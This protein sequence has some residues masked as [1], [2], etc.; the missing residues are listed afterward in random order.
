[1]PQE[2]AEELQQRMLSGVLSAES[3][4]RLLDIQVPIQSSIISKLISWF[5]CL[6]PHFLYCSTIYSLIPLHCTVLYCTVLCCVVLCCTVL[7]CSELDCTVQ[8]SIVVYSKVLY[9]AI[10]CSLQIESCNESKVFSLVNSKFPHPFLY[11]APQ[12]MNW[13]L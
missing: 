3:H 10:Y 12:R 9:C 5:H 4:S 13:R 2:H 8:N 7:Y 11:F 1:M 6:Y